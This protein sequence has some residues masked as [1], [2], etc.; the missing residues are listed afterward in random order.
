[1]NINAERNAY[2]RQPDSRILKIEP[3][4]E[5]RPDGE[6]LEAVFIRAPIIL[7]VGERR[8]NPKREECLSCCLPE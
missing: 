4:G 8:Y 6:A 1:M 5:S 3:E 7:S 2:G